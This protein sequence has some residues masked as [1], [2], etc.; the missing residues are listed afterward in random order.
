MEQTSYVIYKI[1]TETPLKKAPSFSAETLD[2]LSRNRLVRCFDDSGEW[3]VTAYGY[4]QKA[5]CVF[6]FI[7]D[8]ET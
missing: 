4:I 3:L 5:D 1:L 2:M 6:A 8:D 7:Y